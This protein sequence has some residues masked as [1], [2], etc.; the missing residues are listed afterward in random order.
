MWPA[1]HSLP[2]PAVDDGLNG[3]KKSC[4]GKYKVINNTTSDVFSQTHKQ[5]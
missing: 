3:L 2:T 5:H 1:G 4:G